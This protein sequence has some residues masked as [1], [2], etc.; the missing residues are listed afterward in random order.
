MVTVRRRMDGRIVAELDGDHDNPLAIDSADEIEAY[1]EFVAAASGRV[2][3]IGVGLGILASLL[4]MKPEVTEIVAT[5]IEPV[6]LDY[7]G[8][9]TEDGRVRLV[10]V[11]AWN[12]SWLAGMRFDHCYISIWHVRNLSTWGE[13]E[14]LR[15]KYAPFCGRVWVD[16]EALLDEW[17]AFDERAGRA[18]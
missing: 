13:K 6:L 10:Q 17:K 1:R 4:L 15:S 2:L 14:E 9:L 7:C 12:V 3:L 8:A 16:W 5:D 18:A 11:D